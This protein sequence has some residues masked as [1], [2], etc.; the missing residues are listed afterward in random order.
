M[1]HV[2]WKNGQFAFKDLES[3]PAN[4]EAGSIWYRSDINRLRTQIN[5]SSQ[6]IAK[7]TFKLT[8][9]AT[10]L[11]LPPSANPGEAIIGSMTKVFQFS[12][13]T[14][15]SL[16]L[17]IN[18]PDYYKTNST[19]DLDVNW[20]PTSTNTGTV[21]WGMEYK[22]I[23]ADSGDLID[24]SSSSE[25]TTEDAALGTIN[26]YQRT[27]VAILSLPSAQTGNEL[28]MRIFRDASHVNDTYTDDASLVSI[29]LTI[30]NG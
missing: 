27:D 7:P 25:A 26:G 2:G 22:V 17:T 18:L 30:T 14:E 9:P 11:T 20:A 1:S 6:D 19:I 21:R 8:I 15:E 16:Y 5:G 24:N 23:E 12:Q 4:P 3:D 29:D 28:L 13:S 10:R